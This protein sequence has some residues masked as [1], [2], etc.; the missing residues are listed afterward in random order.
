M[1]NRDKITAF[2]DLI[3]FNRPIGV[4]LLLWPT[5][6]AL[7][8]ASGQ[9]PSFKL[10][11]IFTAGSWLMRSAGCIFNDI[12]DR[13]ID[14]FVERT[15][16]RPLTSGRLSV[17]EALSFAALLLAAAAS[18]L[19]FLPLLCFKLALLSLLVVIIY[20]YSKR[21]WH[22]PQAILGVAYS[23]GV[24]MA[25]AAVHNRIPNLAWWV[26]LPA[27]VWPIIYDTMYAMADKPDDL[28]IGVK[29]SAILFGRFD[30]LILA[31]LQVVFTFLLLNL[32][33]KAQLTAYYFI[34]VA[35]STGLMLYHQYLIRHHNR[36]D[37]F[38]AFLHNQWI[39]LVFLLGIAASV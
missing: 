31:G 2:A 18:L 35:I 8:L 21:F 36:N 20:P 22:M 30:R 38:K 16:Q 11:I 24:L 3:R 13:N 23:A 29:S 7:W 33:I 34:A 25:F 10:L 39:G 27:L 28:K 1:L 17:K 12:A 19:L 9:F 37:C 14:R 5:L 32:G 26:F 15:K 6:W 4:L